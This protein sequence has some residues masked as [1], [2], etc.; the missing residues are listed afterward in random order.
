MT[1]FW[2]FHKENG[3]AGTAAKLSSTCEIQLLYFGEP[4]F[5]DL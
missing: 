1:F 3:S 4:Q 2:D 5:S